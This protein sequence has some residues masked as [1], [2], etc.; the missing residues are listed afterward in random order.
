ME[1]K[2]FD[3]IVVGGGHAGIEAARASAAKGVS[4]ALIT[5]KKD[6]IGQMSCNPAIGGLGK[7]HLVKEVDALGGLMGKIIDEGGI[8]FRILN[9]S[10][11]AAV[12]SSRAQADRVLYRKAAFKLVSEIENLSLIFSKVKKI[13]FEGSTFKSMILEDGLEVFAKAIVITTGTF[14]RGLMHTG[15]EKTSGGRVG[16]P[17]SNG[18]SDSI[19]S[20]GL[21]MIRLKT[22]TPPRIR[23]S[24]IN[25]DNLEEQ[26]GDESPTPFSFTT[27][28]ISQKQLPC[29]ITRT[30]EEVHKLILENKER[31]PM[32]NGQIESH[33][34]RYCPSIEDKVFRFTD[35]TGHNIFLEPEG[36]DCD[37]V[38]PNGI[39]TCLPL[40]IQEGI[41]RLI[42]GLENAEILQAGYA[43][44]YDAVDARVLKPTLEV[45]E[46]KGLFLAGQINGTSGY[47]EAAAQGLLAG[48]N[49]AINV[50]GQQPL[51]IS[52]SEA[53]LGV[54]VDD[55]ISRGVDEPYRMFTSRAEYRLHLRE[56][57]AVDRLTPL[58]IKHGLID[59][60]L[61]SLYNKRKESL[62]NLRKFC[63]T[64]KIKSNQET[65][66]WLSSIGASSL[67]ETVTVKE[68]VRRPDLTLAQIFK[69]IQNIGEV[70]VP[71]Y[72][73]DEY[74]TL[75]TEYKFA[76]YLKRQMQE[77]EKLKKSESETIPGT[78]PYDKL[79][80]M[81]IEF[82]EKLK[83][84]KPHSLAHAM[85]IPG[86]TP[87]VI[88]QLAVYIKR[89][90]E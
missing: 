25:L 63:E 27:K 16:E 81:R 68:L 58:G 60:K 20:L 83:K 84:H 51:I 26:H 43:V 59:S 77:I 29:W 74:V 64:T 5:M 80:N 82:R 55:L 34:P 33:G 46:V 66:D 69:F 1:S 42:P 72:T 88:S 21:P 57:N 15:S 49:A 18:L 70:S 31:S 30:N 39:S 87:T 10:K 8:Q 86:M 35:K 3:V 89:Y 13:N 78:F 24:S 85:R 23:L 53:Y 28:E 36:Y 44:E 76:G 9:S 65:Q 54:M 90:G 14:L 11:G 75:E 45:K 52:R 71:K 19:K 62:E 4:T 7:G 37:V 79:D 17:P 48:A 6:D 67:K 47:E 2:T 56:D 32:F 40:D 50:L 73:S 38:Y 12:R 41:L 61:L 22:G